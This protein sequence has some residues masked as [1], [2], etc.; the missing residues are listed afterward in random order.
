MN[1]YEKVNFLN[2]IDEEQSLTLK[3][4][5]KKKIIHGTISWELTFWSTMEQAICLTYVRSAVWGRST[6][7]R[8]RP[9]WIM[10]DTPACGGDMIDA[11]VPQD[12]WES[13]VSTAWEP[14]V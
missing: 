8:V 13:P 14:A 2:S 12:P 9:I 4:A 11:L 5:L 3:A 7:S 1:S 6:D 10:K